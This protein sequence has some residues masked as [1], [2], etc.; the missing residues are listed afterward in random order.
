MAINGHR[1]TYNGTL[2]MAFRMNDENRLTAFIGSNCQGITIDGREYRF[3]ER[4]QPKI[5]FIPDENNEK[6]VYQ[7]QITG[8]GQVA[9]PIV[10]KE[11]TPVVKQG[12]TTVPSKVKGER[13]LLDIDNTLSGKWLQVTI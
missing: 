10:S 9:L 11:T 8:T 13:L 1:V 6:L 12:D 4:P 2:S 5:V 3:A 7:V